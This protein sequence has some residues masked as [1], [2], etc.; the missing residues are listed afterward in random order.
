MIMDTVKLPRKSDKDQSNAYP[1][2]RY[3]KPHMAVMGSNGG[4]CSWG[5]QG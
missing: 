2:Y 5:G 1:S 4:G 3:V